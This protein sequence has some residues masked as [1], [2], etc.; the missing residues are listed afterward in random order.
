MQSERGLTEAEW[1]AT[2]FPFLPLPQTV[3]GVLKVQAWDKRISELA[4]KGEVEEGL[5]KIMK[6]IRKQLVEGASSEVT[7]PGDSITQGRNW[8]PEPT[9]QIPRVVDALA[10]FSKGGHVAGPL[11]DKDKS[12]YKVNPIMA[13]R[14]PG[15]H[16]RVVA[17]L[18]YPPG[19]S[20]NEGIPVERLSDW[21][22]QMT[23]AAG[24]AKM[25]IYAG[26]NSLLA[27]SDLKDAYK[28]IPVTLQQRHLQAYSFCG[29][30]FVELKLM[31]GDR[32]A[33]QFFDKLHYAILQ[34]F[35]HPYTLL[36]QLARGRTVDDIPSVVPLQAKETLLHFV[37]TYRSALDSLNIQAAPDDP[38]HTKAFD[39][40]SEGE[41]LGIRFNTE[42]FTW[43]LPHDKLHSLVIAVR[44][45]AADRSSHSLRELQSVIGKLIHISQLAPPLKTFTSEAIFLM[46]SHIE[47]LSGEHGD[48]GDKDRDRKIFHPTEEV[49][50]DLV[51][52]AAVMA[53]TYNFP[54]PIV[55]PDPPIPLCAV[56]IYPDASGNIGGPTSPALGVLFPPQDLQHAAAFSLIFPT[57]FLLNSNGSGLVA[58]TTS[59]LESLGLIIPMVVAPYRC[60]G[61]PLHVTIDNVAVV[62]AFHKRRSNDRLAHTIIRAAYL[63]AGA[64]GCNLFV[65]W[66]PRRSDPMTRIADDLTHTDFKSTLALDRFADTSTMP[67]FPPPISEWMRAPVQD[68]DLGHRIIA[69]MKGQYSDLF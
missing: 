62:F 1:R 65:S 56:L 36:P 40:T 5:V 43:A 21:V 66:A 39:C 13:I 60:V 52:V 6:D 42:T 34:A 46:R 22:V 32:R 35:V 29:A 9:K 51:M 19:Q 41:V 2:G 14:K 15:D 44:E 50:L 64:L 28:M 63:L 53:D 61:R 49:S 7:A 33:C 27:C 18:K 57:N 69:W 37:K 16:V 8:L 25:I 26:R 45:I 47:E 68:R 58:D 38:S 11:F 24:F 48:I 55:D 54:L 67:T 59:T 31:F 23:T 10:A 30:L 3:Q 17:N 12:Q 20:F 4:S